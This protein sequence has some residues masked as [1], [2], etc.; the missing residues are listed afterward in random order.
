MKINLSQG[1]S[2]NSWKPQI[3]SSIQLFLGNNA[4]YLQ[5]QI[6]ANFWTLGTLFRKHVQDRHRKRNLW[7]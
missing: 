2:K 5:F 4:K 7:T 1:K 3:I 6:M